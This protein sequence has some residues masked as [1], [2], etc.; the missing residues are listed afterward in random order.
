MV[1]LTRFSK[2]APE[3]VLSRTIPILMRNVAHYI[4]NDLSSSLAKVVAYCLK[5]ITC[6][7][8]DTLA[9]A[10]GIKGAAFVLMVRLLPHFKGRMKDVLIKWW[11]VLVTFCAVSRRDVADHDRLEIVINLLDSHINCIARRYLLEILTVLALWEDIRRKLTTLGAFHLLVEAAGTGSVI[12][13]ER[14][15]QTVEL[16][17][18]TQGARHELVELG[19]ISVLVELMLDGDQCTK[20]I[21]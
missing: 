2:H 18:I 11:L 17:G 7:G 20:L 19:V 6:R 3:H 10:M 12:C 4:P 8:D 14:A 1:K 13:R 9:M 15:Y 21:A 5:C 16:L